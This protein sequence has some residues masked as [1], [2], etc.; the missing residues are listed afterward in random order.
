MT[1]CRQRTYITSCTIDS[2]IIKSTFYL[3]M[4]ILRKKASFDSRV[5]RE[6]FQRRHIRFE[7]L[8]VR[9]MGYAETICQI[10]V[11]FIVVLL[12]NPNA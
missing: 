6:I 3:Y 9:I 5:D 11:T 10:L 8:D 1:A 4:T 2:S 12:A 7:I